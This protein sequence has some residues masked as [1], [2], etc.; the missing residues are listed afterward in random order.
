[1][2][3]SVA[4]PV[5][6][7]P[8]TERSMFDSPS[9]SPVSFS[10]QPFTS[11]T[12]E[13]MKAVAHMSLSKNHLVLLVLQSLLCKSRCLDSLQLLLSQEREV[14]HHFRDFETSG[15]FRLK[16]YKSFFLFF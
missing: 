15:T 2:L 6:N 4:S 11:D 13:W 1:M 10:V 3:G 12:K 14:E 7:N 16:F 8:F 9:V 5:S